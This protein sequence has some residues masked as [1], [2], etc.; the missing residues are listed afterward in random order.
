MPTTTSLEPSRQ[1]PDATRVP[2]SPASVPPPVAEV[3][4]ATTTPATV[5]GV[6]ATTAMRPSKSIM[7]R[8][9]PSEEME[10]R[11]NAEKKAP[12]PGRVYVFDVMS[13]EE[14]AV[15]KDGKEP[16]A[17]TRDLPDSHLARLQESERRAPLEYR[18][19]PWVLA[20]SSLVFFVTHLELVPRMF[21]GGRRTDVKGSSSAVLGQATMLAVSGVITIL[22]TVSLLACVPTV[23]A[24]CLFAFVAERCQ[25]PPTRVS[26]RPDVTNAPTA[27]REAWFFVNGVATTGSGAQDDINELHGLVRRPITAIV[28]HSLGLWFDL[29]QSVMQR[30]LGLAT[31][32]LR[33]GYK[34][35]HEAVNNPAMERVV[36]IAHSQGAILTSA[37]I[38]QLVADLPAHLLAKVEVYTFGS[39]AN[40]FSLHAYAL[41]RVEHFANMFDYVARHGV[42][43]HCRGGAYA[44]GVDDTVKAVYGR[45]PGRVFARNR[46]GHMLLDH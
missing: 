24:V 39:A 41:A 30:D 12:A 31:K 1:A 35:I 11:A 8:L 7:E 15:P 37:W 14:P 3:V 36:V 46:T 44:P 19:S 20:G 5:P 17:K 16:L 6:K 18:T 33:E 26:D 4:A 21:V 27:D 23:A 22:G 43:D 32:D 9:F 40:H 25:G 45:Y 2:V 42:L 28:N 38:D 29:V 13:E 34:Y 10:R